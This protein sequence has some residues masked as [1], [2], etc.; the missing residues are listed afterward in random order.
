MMDVEVVEL[1][2][3]GFRQAPA[4]PAALLLWLCNGDAR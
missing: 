2:G 3:N 4:H 1:L